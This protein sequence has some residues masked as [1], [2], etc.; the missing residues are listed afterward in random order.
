MIEQRPTHSVGCGR[1]EFSSLRL[2]RGQTLRTG[3]N[4]Y[5]FGTYSPAMLSHVEFCDAMKQPGLSNPES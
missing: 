3:W 2:D 5:K 4:G 1:K